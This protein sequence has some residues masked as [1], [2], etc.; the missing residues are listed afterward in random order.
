MFALIEFINVLTKDVFVTDKD[1][2]ICGV[3]KPPVNST[4]EIK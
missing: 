4:F 1:I 2:M 3:I